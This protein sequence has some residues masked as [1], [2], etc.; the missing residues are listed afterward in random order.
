[1]NILELM[2]LRETLRQ[3]YLN[4]I[5]TAKTYALAAGEIGAKIT[6]LAAL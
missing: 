5:L 2:E 6:A 4:G 1:M 3:A